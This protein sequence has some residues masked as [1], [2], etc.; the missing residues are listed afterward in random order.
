MENCGA[1][2]TVLTAAHGYDVVKDELRMHE[3]LDARGEFYVFRRASLDCLAFFDTGIGE[4]AGV[5]NANATHRIYDDFGI[6]IH[7]THGKNLSSFSGSSKDL[8]CAISDPIDVQHLPNPQ[9]RTMLET[10]KAS[11]HRAE[12]PTSGWRPL[13]ASDALP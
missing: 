6:F 8:K 5:V 9:M 4:E 7:A 13:S 11:F 10:H 3:D 2:M 12:T 1:T